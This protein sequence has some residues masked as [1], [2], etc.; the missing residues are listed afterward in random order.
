M[1]GVITVRL[2]DGSTKE[3]PTG[4]TA[5]GLASAIGKRL[6]AAAVAAV[7]DGVEVDLDTVL[8]TGPRWPW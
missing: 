8:P 3:L 2:P 6:A 1:A 7:V 4:T 5:L